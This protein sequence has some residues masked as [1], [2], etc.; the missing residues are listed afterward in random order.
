V[1]APIP[2]PAP[3]RLT[4]ELRQKIEVAVDRLLT[5]LDAADPDPDL[6][7]MTSEIGFY[8]EVASGGLD[9]CEPDENEEPDLGWT[10]TAKQTGF[11]WAGGLEDLEKEH[12]GREPQGDEEPYLAGAETDLELDEAEHGIVDA[13]GA[14]EQGFLDERHGF[15]HV[16]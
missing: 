14:A 1:S 13:A 7:P 2:F 5:I 9:E 12:D 16:A 6:E 8:G 11:G 10:A 4:P 3:T 15:N